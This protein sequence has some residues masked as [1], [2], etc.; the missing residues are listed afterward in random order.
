MANPM[1]P[2]LISWAVA[3]PGTPVIHASGRNISTMIAPMGTRSGRQGS[4]HH[5]A[6]S[7]YHFRP[8]PS[9]GQSPPGSTGPHKRRWDGSVWRNV[10]QDIVLGFAEHLGRRLE[11]ERRV[12]LETPGQG[13]RR[14][15]ELLVN[16]VAEPADGLGQ[17]DAGGDDV[18]PARRAQMLSPGIERE[19][20]KAA[21]DPPKDAQA[22]EAA[23]PK[24]DDIDGMLAVPAPAQP[25]DRIRENV[26]E[27]TRR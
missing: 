19:G 14:A 12:D 17:Q 15:V 2:K 10:L 4:G 11:R 16:I 7:W 23:V 27:A 25:A 18:Q 8:S 13:G 6:V 22:A 1:R 21:Q 26:V 20:D 5:P 3:R 9:P 24:G